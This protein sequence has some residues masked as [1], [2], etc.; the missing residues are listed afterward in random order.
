VYLNMH[1]SPLDMSLLDVDEVLNSE[2]NYNQKVLV[3][4]VYT[5]PVQFSGTG[6]YTL[7]EQNI[8]T[9]VGK[10]WLKVECTIKAPDNLWQSFINAELKTGDSVKHARVRLF[11]PISIND[12]INHYEFYMSIPPYFVSTKVKVYISS[13][14]NFKGTVHELKVTELEKRE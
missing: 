14:Y 6:T 5:K 2:K 13:T 1:P 12:S 3:D 8:K 4:S 10:A 9:I 11:S 7:F